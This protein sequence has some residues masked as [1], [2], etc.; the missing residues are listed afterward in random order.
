MT[1]GRINQVTIVVTAL[2]GPSQFAGGGDSTGAVPARRTALP[3]VSPSTAAAPGGAPG[4]SQR[5]AAASGREPIRR[6]RAAVLCSHN[7]VPHDGGRCR[8]RRSPGPPG[9]CPPSEGAARHRSHPEGRSPA[10]RRTPNCVWG[11]A[12]QG[13]TAHRLPQCCVTRQARTQPS[14][15]PTAPGGTSRCRP[16][17]RAHA[18]APT[19]AGPVHRVGRRAAAASDAMRLRSGGGRGW[20]AACR[21]ISKDRSP[22]ASK[23]PHTVG[24]GG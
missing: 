5:A 19:S 21:S 12:D 6:G 11:S 2:A 8:T 23:P 3:G 20:P 22:H 10:H 24:T 7:R 13:S 1:T 4:T 16:V 14:V 17:P 15:Q 9:A 18:P